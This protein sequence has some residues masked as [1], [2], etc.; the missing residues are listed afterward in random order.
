MDQQGQSILVLSKKVTDAHVKFE[1]LANKMEVLKTEM[2]KLHL[3]AA[4]ASDEW[5]KYTKELEVV[6]GTARPISIITP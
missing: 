6:V 1:K 3:E 4:H 2:Q 5:V